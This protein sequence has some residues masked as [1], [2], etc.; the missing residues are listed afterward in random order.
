ML[1]HE[2]PVGYGPRLPHYPKLGPYISTIDQ[3]LDAAVSS[4]ILLGI[5]LLGERPSG[6]QIAGMLLIGVG[7]ALLDG[8]PFAAILRRIQ[9]R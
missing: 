1:T 3:L 5:M 7:I 4:T 6:Q 2:R 8:R 9:T